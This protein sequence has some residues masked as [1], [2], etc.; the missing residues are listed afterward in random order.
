MEGLLRL[1]HCPD[2]GRKARLVTFPSLQT[3]R[4]DND[5]LRAALANGDQ[6]GKVPGVGWTPPSN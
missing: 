2:N 6:V 5:L 1:Q 4:T 3:L